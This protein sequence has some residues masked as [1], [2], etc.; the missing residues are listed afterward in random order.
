[1]VVESSLKSPKTTC[2]TPPYHLALIAIEIPE[3]DRYQ[4]LP[5][6]L[7]KV[8]LQRRTVGRFCNREAQYLIYSP[9]PEKYDH[10]IHQ[11]L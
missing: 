11:V 9:T 8:M 1:M 2:V 5:D 6:L 7:L 4:Q 10:I 3:K